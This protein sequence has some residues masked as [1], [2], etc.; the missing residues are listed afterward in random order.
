MK[1]IFLSIRIG[2]IYFKDK[3]ASTP[4][5]M[6]D[7]TK[8]NMYTN[9]VYKDTRIQKKDTNGNYGVFAT[10]IIPAGTMIMMEH[11]VQAEPLRLQSLMKHSATFSDELYPRSANDLRDGEDIYEEKVAQNSFAAAEHDLFEIGHYSSLFNHS[12]L[13]NCSYRGMS[14]RDDYIP[15]YFMRI[16]TVSEISKDEELVISYG[17]SF[18]HEMRSSHRITCNCK[19]THKE[20]TKLWEDHQKLLEAYTKLHSDPSKNLYDKYIGTHLELQISFL[21]RLLRKGYIIQSRPS[22]LQKG[23]WRQGFVDVN[24]ASDMGQ[25]NLTAEFTRF[26]SYLCVRK[27]ANEVN[28]LLSQLDAMISGAA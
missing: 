23:P 26:E 7:N 11:I 18:G 27:S 28:E 19:R 3:E 2:D 24:Q 6:H 5:H 13:N 14:E 17:H 20:R 21:Q 12:C 16:Y 9:V 10:D 25:K 4:R 1:F 8:S 22:S 15:A